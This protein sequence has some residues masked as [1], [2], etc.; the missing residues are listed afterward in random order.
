M[1]IL[2]EESVYQPKNPEL[3]QSLGE[4]EISKNVIEIIPLHKSEFDFPSFV[5][6][7]KIIDHEYFADEMKCMPD[8]TAHI[9]VYKRKF[10]NIPN[11]KVNYSFHVKF[12][13][14]FNP[15]QVNIKYYMNDFTYIYENGQKKYIDILG[16]SHDLE[17]DRIDIL[18]IEDSL[19]SN[20]L[21]FQV[22]KYY[23]SKKNTCPDCIL[24]YFNQILHKETPQNTIF[25]DINKR[26]IASDFFDHCPGWIK[27]SFQKK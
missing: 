26:A 11:I 10:I 13:V 25:P 2:F 3:L 20:S 15:I 6:F 27:V 17:E 9:K 1:N 8:K 18:P 22:A 4:R 7:A 5:E 19:K 16:Q 14:N 21:L 23:T 24:A 12:G